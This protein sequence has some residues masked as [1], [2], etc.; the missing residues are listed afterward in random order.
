MNKELTDPEKAVYAKLLAYARCYLRWENNPRGTPMDAVASAYKSELK[1]G[2][3]PSATT[4]G[5]QLFEALLRRLK[6][7]IR[8]YRKHRTI[9]EGKMVL[10]SQLSTADVHFIQ[11][12]EADRRLPRALMANSRALD[13]EFSDHAKEAAGW[14]RDA[15]DELFDGETRR[16]AILLVSGF[17]QREITDETGLTRGQ[18]RTHMQR[19]Q[20]VVSKLKM[21]QGGDGEEG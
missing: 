13:E 6:K 9:F 20:G 1:R 8:E 11:H 4:E 12:V 16:V 18:L 7:K 5:K 2:P 10:D 19:I 3:L 17:K 14:I 21:D 15:I